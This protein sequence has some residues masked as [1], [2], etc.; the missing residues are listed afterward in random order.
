MLLNYGSL[1]FLFLRAHSH[2][3]KANAKVKM[4]FDVWNFFFDPFRLFFD[5][6]HFR[7]RFHS[8]WMDLKKSVYLHGLESLMVHSHLQFIRHELLCELFSPSNRKKLVYNPLFNFSV[9]TKVD[10]ISSVNVST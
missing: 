8:E 2:R 10:Q 6:F 7:V 5:F 9:H 3:V 1:N 4:F